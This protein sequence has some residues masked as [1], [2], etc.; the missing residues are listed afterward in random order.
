MGLFTPCFVPRGGFLYTVVVRGGK[1]LPS[2][3]RVLGVCL[4]GGGVVLDETDSCIILPL[5]PTLFLQIH[6]FLNYLFSC[7]QIC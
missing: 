6:S 3:S 2:S 7:H 4:G 5:S 1:V